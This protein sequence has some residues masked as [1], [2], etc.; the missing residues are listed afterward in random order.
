MSANPK[1]DK[2]LTPKINEEL[3]QLESKKHTNWKVD[4][5]S[6][7]TF[8]QRYTYGQQVKGEVISVPKDKTD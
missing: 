8:F 7:W 1:S 6:E 4:K 5:G 3:L 2:G